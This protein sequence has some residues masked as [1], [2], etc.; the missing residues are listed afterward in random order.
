MNKIIINGEQIRDVKNLHRQLKQ[1]LELPEY[2]GENLDALWDCLTGWVDFPIVIEWKH[3]D[4]SKKLL[5]SSAE[6]FWEVFQS[7][8]ADGYDITIVKS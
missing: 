8:R 4:Q 7:A 6:A 3:F 1:D 5:G 2:Y